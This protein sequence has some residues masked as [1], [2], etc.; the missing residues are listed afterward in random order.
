METCYVPL[1]LFCC[2]T[3][4]AKQIFGRGCWLSV[5]SMYVLGQET[6]ERTLRI[7]CAFTGSG[8]RLV[9]LPLLLMQP[10]NDHNSLTREPFVD[11]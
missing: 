8:W 1:Y 5:L 11:G 4:T 9:S 6:Y 2:D 3:F 10:S 7:I